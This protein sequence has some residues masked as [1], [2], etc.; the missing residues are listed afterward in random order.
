[1]ATV[2]HP[3][4]RSQACRSCRAGTVVPNHRV[5]ISASLSAG[6]TATAAASPRLPTSIP[7]HRS[8]ITGMVIIP[9]P[10][11]ADEGRR[12]TATFCLTGS[13]HHSW[14]HLRRPDQFEKRG[15]PPERVSATASPDAAPSYSL[16]R[17]LIFMHV[18]GGHR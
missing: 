10:F 6:P 9:R 4:S 5:L 8:V 14:V 13:K 15:L 11:C 7:A 12:F 18:G 3:S 1:M 2:V 16:T 17:G